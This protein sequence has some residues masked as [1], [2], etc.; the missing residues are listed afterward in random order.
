LY[1]SYGFIIINWRLRWAG[2]V[3]GTREARTTYVILI[4]KPL[5]NVCSEGPVTGGHMYWRN[6]VAEWIELAQDLVKWPAFV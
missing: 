2:Y 1:R 6:Q 3:A 4:R 5:G